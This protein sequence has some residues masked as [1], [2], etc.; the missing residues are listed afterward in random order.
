MRI[1]PKLLVPILLVLVAC[2]Q[3]GQASAFGGATSFSGHH[4]ELQIT[5]RL[6]ESLPSPTLGE[7]VEDDFETVTNGEHYL[8]SIAADG[9]E[10]TLESLSSS[11]RLGGRLSQGGPLAADIVAETS[12]C[13][14]VDTGLTSGGQLVVWRDGEGLR[15]ELTTLDEGCS[16]AGCERG[17]LVEV[18]A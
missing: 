10:F 3:G 4:Y 8:L 9:R 15:A 16:V 6:S 1:F 13:F 11:S 2:A 18:A 14:D 12:L 17:H 5:H 7:W